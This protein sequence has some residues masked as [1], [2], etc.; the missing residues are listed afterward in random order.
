MAGFT[1]SCYRRPVF[2]ISS[3]SLPNLF[4]IFFYP[5]YDPPYPLFSNY[6]VCYRYRI[7]FVF[8]IRGDGHAFS[9]G[10]G[11]WNGS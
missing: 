4:P 9:G 7:V 6:V 3:I 8:R 11:V 5:H 2:P 10:G 1:R